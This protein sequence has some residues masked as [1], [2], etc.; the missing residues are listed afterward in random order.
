M[1]CKDKEKFKTSE[2]SSKASMRSKGAI[3]KFLNILDVNL[4]NKL[5]K[6]WTIDARERFNINGNLFLNDNGKAVANKVAFKQIDNAKGITYPNEINFDNLKGSKKNELD[7]N[8]NIES[9]TVKEDN[10]LNEIDRILFN[11]KDGRITVDEVLENILSNY[12]NLSPIGREFLEKSRRLVGRTG[13]KIRFVPESSLL[14]ERA[15]MQIDSSTN[16]I[17]ISKERLSK[18]S[19]D[20]AIHGIIHELAHAQTLQA[21]DNPITFE[22]K[23]FSKLIQQNFYKYWN[24]QADK[25]IRLTGDHSLDMQSYGFKNEKEFVAEIYSNRQFREELKALDEENNTSFWKNF[26]NSLRRLFGLT[27]TKESNK[28]IEEIIDY[29]EA[30]R[31]DY[32]GSNLQRTLFA[33]ESTPKTKIKTVEDRLNRTLNK[34]KDNLDNLL[35]L[36]EKYKKQNEA[37]GSKFEA[38]I[39]ELISEINKVD[40]INQWKGVA[41]YVKSMLSTIKQLDERLSKEDLTADNGLEIIDLYRTYLSSYDLVDDVKRLISSLKADK[42]DE[43][44]EDIVKDIK[45]TITEAIGRHSTLEDDFNAKISDILKNQLNTF[46]YLPQVEDK[47][48]KKLEIE[49][50]QRGINNIGKDEW[51]S[52]QMNGP[53]LDE[54][55]TDL[56]DA[57]SELLT[58]IGTDISWAGQ[59]FGDIINNNSRLVS[60]VTNLITQAR[61]KIIEQTREG[62]FKE[63]KLFEQL[64]KEKNTSKPSELYKNIIDTDST[65]Y[66]VLKGEYSIKFK[67]E[68]KKLKT[69]KEEAYNKIK[70]TKNFKDKEYVKAKNDFAKFKKENTIVKD[71]VRIPSSKWKNDFSKLSKTEK[72]VLNYFIETTKNT[73]KQTHGIQSLISEFVGA[74]YYDLPSVTKSDEERIIEGNLKGLVKDKIKDLTEIRPDDIG[75]QEQRLDS[76]GNSIYYLRVHYR[77]KLTPD[78][79]SLDLFTINRLNRINGINYQEKEAIAM[80][81]EAIKMVA[82]NKEYYIKTK[83]GE[84]VLNKYATRVKEAT[85]SSGTS[86]EAKMIENI[87]EKNLYDILHVQYDKL[88]PLD[89]NKVISTANSWVSSVGL[90]LNTFSAAANIINAQSQ[91]FLEKIAGNHLSKGS[92]S[93]AHSIYTK[94]LANIAGDY[95][96]P[97][98]QSFVNQVNQM[99]DTFGGFTVKQQDYIKNT[100]AKTA[101]NFESLQFMHEGGEHYV[102]SIMVMATLDSIKVMND[103]N[104]YIDKNGN[105]VEKDKA[106]SVL[107]MLS[108]DS[109]GIVRLD[110]K[111]VYTNRSFNSKL[112]EGGK[113]QIMLFVKKKLFD[114]MGNYDS[115]MQPEAYRHWWGKMILLFRRYLIS[116]AATRFRGLTKALVKEED[117]TEEDIHFNN[118]LRTT[119]EGSYVSTIRFL[120]HTVY[121]AL[122]QLKFDILSSNWNELSDD[123]KAGIKKSVMELALTGAI[124]PL[125]GMLAVGAAGDDDDKQWLWTIAFLSRRLESELSQFRDP[126]EATK[127]TKSPIPSLR[128]IEQTLDV[129]EYILPWNWSEINDKYETGK[130]K[131]ELKIVRKTEKL[132]PILSKIDVTAEELYNGLNSRW[133]R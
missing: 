5:N 66:I 86:N 41:V 126:R 2:A 15:V 14:N 118:A 89:V 129:M 68:Y 122:R 44:G 13:A 38:H 48:R 77:G 9:P 110:D 124:L 24:L 59:M 7:W 21:L 20:K 27:K 116:Q 67:E 28:L 69:A 33:I 35:K 19:L 43:I 81:V 75:Y 131:G 85:T 130:N 8:K 87:I 16:T 76:K 58:G 57:I 37:K 121:P 115:N 84:S 90:S 45:N 70:D 30:D 52:K 62:D 72:E 61:E 109:D 111:V 100:I 133:G 117:L 50:K 36:S 120:R 12:K 83:G 80:K 94:D 125:I 39:Q 119:E 78:Q 29:V 103:N 4:F 96:R 101:I 23:Q 1:S 93:K 79:Q 60:I 51:I 91:I 105:I 42:I 34:A 104:D 32:R 6:K 17:E 47:W 74:I 11:N 108:K 123:K 102:Q 95:S 64:V 10:S 31:R 106:V 132:V 114:T 73:D 112:K 49:Y 46:N 88:G 99:F 22:E 128:I 63:S 25:N 56:D 26:I 3:D 18:Y 107:D 54:I 82:K 92:V 98:K 40:S 65:G 55:Q 53:R 97:I 113:E 71:G 127:I